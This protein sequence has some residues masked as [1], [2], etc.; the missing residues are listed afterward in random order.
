MKGDYMSK[1]D[2]ELEKE[3]IR[4]KDYAR[5][6]LIALTIMFAGPVLS[7]GNLFSTLS[8]ISGVIGIL[9]VVC[10]YAM[11]YKIPFLGKPLFLLVASMALSAQA[12]FLVFQ[13]IMS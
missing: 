8:V 11:E 3:Y 13:L 4:W 10:W 1:D 7:Q 12:V 6:L 2:G 9:A 5:V